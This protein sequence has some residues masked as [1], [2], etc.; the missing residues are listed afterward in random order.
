[1]KIRSK[2]PGDVVYFSTTSINIDGMH[3]VS[4]D[5][6]VFN[7]GALPKSRNYNDAD[8]S[9]LCG[10]PIDRR[11]GGQAIIL[12]YY[13]TAIYS[14]AVT[15]AAIA[16]RIMMNIVS[17]PWRPGNY[18]HRMAL[19]TIPASTNKIY[20]MT[21]QAFIRL[22]RHTARSVGGCRFI[23]FRN[24]STKLSFPLITS[25]SDLIPAA[26]KVERSP[27]RWTIVK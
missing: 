17:T 8:Y 10:N 12:Q 16:V 23:R 5:A 18:P 13:L 14:I 26:P 2:S 3:P 21:W 22:T 19:Q 6:W 11:I 15:N 7:R 25:W 4:P 24:R 27:Q 9:Q 20:I 1:M